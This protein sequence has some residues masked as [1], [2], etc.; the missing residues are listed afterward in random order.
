MIRNFSRSH[1]FSLP[2]LAV[3]L[4]CLAV[5]VRSTAVAQQ[6]AV[7]GSAIAVVDIQRVLLHS[8]AGKRARES[9]EKEFKSKQKFLDGESVQYEKMEKDLTKNLSIMNE[10][11]LKQKSQSLEKKKKELVR[12][13]EDFSDELRRRQEEMRLKI[14]QEIQSIVDG[15]GQSQGFSMILAKENAGVIFMT[16]SVDVTEQIIDL[17]DRKY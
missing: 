16:E 15:F 14:F 7:T 2:P 13:K 5:P 9:F 3:F 12:A 11:T 17:Y 8:K 10:E 4:I 1:F 6:P